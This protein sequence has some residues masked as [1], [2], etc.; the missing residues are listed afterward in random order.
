[1]FGIENTS[2]MCVFKLKEWQLSRKKNITQKIKF[3]ML[4]FDQEKRGETK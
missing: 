2:I 3:T 4:L 1:M